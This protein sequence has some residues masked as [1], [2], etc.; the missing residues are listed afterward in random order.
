MHHPV[1]IEN[2]EELRRREGIDDCELHE[3]IDRLREGDHVKLTLLTP[4]RSPGETVLIRITSIHGTVF[5]GK[6]LKNPAVPGPANLHAGSLVT[7]TRDHIHSIPKVRSG[8]NR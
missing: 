8:N 7:F 6:L 5:R 1:E 4:N 2:I 3:E